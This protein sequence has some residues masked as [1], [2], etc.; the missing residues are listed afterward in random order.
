MGISSLILWGRGWLL[1]AAV[2][3]PLLFQPELSAAQTPVTITWGKPSEV[4]STDPHRS[5]DGTSW[6]VFYLIYDQLMGTDDNLRPV[7]KLAESWEQPSPT[8]YVFHLRRN[9]TFSNGRPLTAA[10]VVGSLKRLTD[11]KLPS[12]WGKQIGAL[13][14]VVA[15]DD[16]TVRLDLVAPNTSLLAVLSVA[17]TSILPM[18]ELDA[19]TFD[20]AKGMLGSGPFMVA[21]HQQD[22]SW[23][24]ERNPRYWQQGRP[25]IDRLVIRIMPD[26]AA[27][28]AGLRDGSVDV[29]TFENPDSPR[30]LRSIP[31][32]QS[33]IQ[34]TPNYFR[35]DVSALQQTSPFKDLRVRQAMALALDRPAIVN[36]VFGGDSAV[37]YPIP[38]A[39]GKQA[40]RDMPSY[41]LPRAERLKMARSLLKE[42]GTPAPRISIIASAVL[43]TYPLIAQV[44]Q[45]DLQE[46]GFVAEV[47][48]VPVAEWYKR[49]FSKETNFDLA[50]SWF[51]GYTDPSIVLNWWAP[52]F[53]G[54][55]VGF[56][57]PVQEY[58]DLV[59][60]LRQAPNGPERDRLMARACTLIGERANML[61][62]VNKPD[63]IGYRRD[64]I[65]ARF[66]TIEG[67]F[68]VF[69][70]VTD[71]KRR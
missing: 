19:G 28:L 11:P 57:D 18:K 25:V 61:A 1:A 13:A 6:T 39:F 29:G 2:A 55:N 50:M 45:R 14:N 64:R 43:V 44:I 59:P 3:T 5:G 60:K 58:I 52:G 24:L 38:A 12:P 67:N 48:Q 42:A 70:Y 65:D 30:L 47:Q 35:L 69:K 56:L 26:D 32:V 21:R 16:H 41:T 37:E 46:A 17:T 53:G 8:S 33:V 34:K 63:Y 4:L 9:A 68:D 62:L 20:P 27:R 23:T 36:A 51:A 49:V 66:G 71:F 7:G 40:C 22:E 54:F 15:L 31:N 10:D